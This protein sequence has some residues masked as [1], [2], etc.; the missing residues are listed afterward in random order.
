MYSRHD[1]VWLSR[2]GWEAAAGDVRPDERAALEL[3]QREGW[4][5]VV[6]RADAGAP[7][8]SISL[9]I[10]LP[11]ERDGR[12]RRI[13]VRAEVAQ[14]KRHAPALLL[15]DALGVAPAAWRENLAKLCASAPALRAYGSL[16]L[17]AL[18]GR[19]YLTGASDIDVLAAPASGAEL[20]ATI[21]LL[22]EHAQALPL[23]GEIV[24]PNGDAVAWKEWRSA[25]PAR[26][27]VLVKSIHAV[28]LAETGAMAATLEAA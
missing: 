23:D 4:P 17:Q 12:K 20:E 22:S 3:W 18:T 11:P 27:R 7:A 21:A 26:A 25:L 16:A 19:H 8:A 2:E 1:L 9:G 6:R 5:A 14:V 15:R 13:A 28:R 10:A 24:F